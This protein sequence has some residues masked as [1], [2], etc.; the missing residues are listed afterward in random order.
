MRINACW[1]DS[2]QEVGK[3]MKTRY[4]G[5]VQQQY[6]TTTT[7]ILTNYKDLNK[8]HYLLK[9]LRTK[10]C[11]ANEGTKYRIS[12]TTITLTQY[13]NQC[14]TNKNNFTQLKIKNQPWINQFLSGKKLWGSISPHLYYF[15]STNSISDQV[16]CP[17]YRR[18]TYCHYE[19]IDTKWEATHCQSLDQH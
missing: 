9:G 4:L 11:E 8:D 10:E 7:T 16:I 17:F 15:Q 18:S 2:Q 1:R 5:S 13:E 14:I 12:S 19:Y 3:L 6:I